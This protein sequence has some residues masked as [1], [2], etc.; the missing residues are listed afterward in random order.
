MCFPP[1]MSFISVFFNSIV[2]DPSYGALVFSLNLCNSVSIYGVPTTFMP[3]SISKCY[4]DSRGK[5]PQ[6]P[7]SK[8]E[9]TF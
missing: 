5:D 4:R 9:P 7:C 2:T 1:K 8:I 6:S 3:G